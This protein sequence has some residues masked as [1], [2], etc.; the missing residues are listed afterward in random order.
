M[1]DRN[2]PPPLVEEGVNSHLVYGGRKVDSITQFKGLKAV[3][4][5]RSSFWQRLTRN[6]LCL[7]CLSAATVTRTMTGTSFRWLHG[8]A[9]S[10]YIQKNASFCG[11]SQRISC[12]CPMVVGGFLIVRISDLLPV[13]EDH[14]PGLTVLL[15][16]QYHLKAPSDCDMSI[17]RI[18]IK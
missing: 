12:F 17:P 6:S 9:C 8:G 16:N 1:G 2:T 10:E 5:N 18:A 7:P 11:C 14:K 15:Y 4:R 3:A 13:K